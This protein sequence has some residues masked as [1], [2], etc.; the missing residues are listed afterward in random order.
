MIILT[1]GIFF[2]FLVW[3]AFKIGKKLGAYECKLEWQERIEKMR[4]D[5]AD[6]QRAGIKGKVVEIFAPYIK[7]FPFSA[8]ECRFIGDPIDYVVFEGMDRGEIKDIYFVEIK[9]NSSKLNNNQNRI[10]ELIEK[11]K[12]KWYLFRM[13]VKE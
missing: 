9:T 10:K 7:G 12:V 11:G 13:Q 4:K 6:K 2:L 5:I 3:L 8:S 1:L